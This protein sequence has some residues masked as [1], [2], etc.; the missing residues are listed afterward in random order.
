MMDVGLKPDI[1][2]GVS[3]GGYAA[4][5]AYGGHER[6]EIIDWFHVSR[7]HFKRK[8]LMRFFPPWDIMANTIQ[9][10]SRPFLVSQDT[11]MNSGLK[12]FYVGYTDLK[13]KTFLVEDI[14]K[15]DDPRKAYRV[16]MKSSMIPFVTHHAPHLDGAVDGGF[17]RA[18]FP[19]RHEVSQRWLIGHKTTL[20]PKRNRDTGVYDRVIDLTI[21]ILNPIACT[22]R[23]IGVGYDLGYRQGVEI[24]EKFLKDHSLDLVS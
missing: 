21:N 4:Y 12:H 8:P 3:C 18:Q 16:I 22:A 7:S 6:T 13:T 9:Y 1:I 10:E 15:I 24:A 11:F 17:L 5:M 2:T 20:H 19:S 23:Q 14:T